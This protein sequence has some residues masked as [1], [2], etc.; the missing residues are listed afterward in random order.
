MNRDATLILD[1]GGRIVWAN[2][3]A[4]ENVG[5]KPGGL[6]GKNYLDFCPVDTHADLLR[7]HKLKLE[8]ETVRFR[9]DL[10]GGKVLSVTSG[11]V[12]VDDR[13]YMFV[14]GR[15]AEGPPAGDEI[16]VGMIAAGELLRE[17]RRALDLNS[18]LLGALK[19]EAR[20]LRGKLSLDPGAPPAVRV[21]AWPLKMVIRRL[22]LHAHHAGGRFQVSTGG[23]PRRAWLK[24]R[25]PR[26]PSTDSKE[27]AVCRK[28]AR[29]Q[30]GQLQVRGRT[31]RLSFPAA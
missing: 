25:L 30:G 2:R 29:E 26:V 14:V 5:L 11:P 22:L 31:L 20:A 12:R 10:G 8:G 23:D 27:F 16:L 6:L 24:I 3:V 15:R 9:I 4:H 28:I 1:L 17:K 13:L 21:Q 19:E 7:L 18:L